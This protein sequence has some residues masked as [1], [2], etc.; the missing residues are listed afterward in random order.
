MS[1]N[2]VSNTVRTQRSKSGRDLACVINQYEGR[3]LMKNFVLIHS[4]FSYTVVRSF[5]G[6][7]SLWVLIQYVSS[8][9]EGVFLIL[10]GHFVC[11]S[12]DNATIASRVISANLEM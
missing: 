10:F 8:Y 9:F 12:G 5:L 11:V 3:H 4:D 7:L 1:N 6:F 2:F